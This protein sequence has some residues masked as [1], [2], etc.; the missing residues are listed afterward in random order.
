[1]ASVNIRKN[2]RPPQ[3]TLN[4]LRTVL[5]YAAVKEAL[6]LP[7]AY[8][9]EQLLDSDKFVQVEGETRRNS[10]WDRYSRGERVPI[11]KPDG[12]I[13]RAELRAP[14]TARWFRSPIWDVLHDRPITR[15]EIE[16]YLAGIPNIR[17]LIFEFQDFEDQA[18][19]EYDPES[20]ALPAIREL[21]VEGIP[22]SEELG[23]IDLLESTILLLAAAH[24]SGS[25][26]LMDAAR[27]LYVAATPKIAETFKVSRYFP[28]GFEA[29]EDRFTQNADT[30]WNDEFVPP[31]HVRLPDLQ[32]NRDYINEPLRRFELDRETELS[33]CSD[34]QRALTSSLQKRPN[35]NANP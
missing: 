8:R 25:T 30:D 9:I 5:W 32:D 11:D 18:D 4:R 35:G 2:T 19:G 1:M 27:A 28:E 12:S 3:T 17:P 22:K 20:P 34:S 33:N 13:E 6:G 21:N 14:G 10:K 31:W 15:F 24:V 29:I 23:G 26:K 7:S 16:D